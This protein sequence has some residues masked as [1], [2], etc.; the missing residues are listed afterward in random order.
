MAET[1]IFGI[2]SNLDTGDIINKMVSLEARPMDLVEA[3]KL[4]EEQKLASFQELKTRLQTF[5]SVVTTLNTESRFIVNKGLFSNNSTSDS[6]KVVGI[7]TTSSA[8]SGTFSLTVNSLATE[9]KIISEGFASTTSTLDKGNVKITV[10]S[11]QKTITLDD[12]NNTLDGLRLAINNLGLDLKATFLNDGSATNPVRLLISGTKTGSDNGVSIDNSISTIGA[13]VLTPITF[14]TTQTAQNA[15]LVVDGVSITKSS[16][17]VTDVINGAALKLESAGSGIISLSTD[18]DAITDKV[19][20]FVQEYNDLFLFLSE[21]LSLDSSSG[22]TG[23]LFGNFAAQNFQQILRSSISSEITGIS[24]SFSFLSQIG[25]TTQTDGTLIIDTNEL[26]DALTTDIQNVSQL[27]SSKGSTTNSSV[28]FVGFTRNTQPGTYNLQVSGGIPEL[29]ASGS[30]TFVDAT[31]SGNFFAG[32]AGTDA[33]GLNFRIASLT[34]G[35][36]GQITLSIGVAEIL[37]RELEN[38]VDTSLNGPLSTEIDTITESIDEFNETLLEQAERL[39]LF[40]E[41]LK[42]RFTNLEIVLGRLNSQKDTFNSAL[43]GI[44]S[45]FTQGK[46]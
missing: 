5:K 23:V 15:S 10:G 19:S 37:N 29:A 40:E 6:N 46:K 26:A 27:F 14:T 22:E 17:T 13:G 42:E 30:T 32:A 12:S 28:T 33:E 11:T 2:N 43:A 3:K 20:D 1:A 16:N 39:L 38:M 35:S 4:I 45:L 7:T 41:N 25:I 21:Q 24:G 44:Q 34:D 18:T 8:S 9:T 36:F 31:G